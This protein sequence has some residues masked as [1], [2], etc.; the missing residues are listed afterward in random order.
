MKKKLRN[1]Q[2]R[3]RQQRRRRVQLKVQQS[4]RPALTIFRS[5]RHIYAQIVAEAPQATEL[6]SNAVHVGS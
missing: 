5:A 3:R 2:V 4:D 1:D 6:Q